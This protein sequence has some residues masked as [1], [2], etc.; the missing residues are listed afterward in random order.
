MQKREK[1]VGRAI[2]IS[3]AVFV[4]TFLFVVIILPSLFQDFL[5][6]Y[7]LGFGVPLSIKLLYYG[8]FSLIPLIVLLRLVPSGKFWIVVLI[9]PAWYLLGFFMY[10]ISFI[11]AWRG[12]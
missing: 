3:T 4:A 9:L 6:M 11:L 10:V 7:V 5:L 12:G 8:L 1:T 2:L